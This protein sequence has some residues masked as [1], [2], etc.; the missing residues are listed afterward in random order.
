V[1]FS[2]KIACV[3]TYLAVRAILYRQNIKKGAKGAKNQKKCYDFLEKSLVLQTGGIFL[4]KI[5]PPI[6]NTKK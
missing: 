6:S 5:R 4:K 2:K 1:L 3:F